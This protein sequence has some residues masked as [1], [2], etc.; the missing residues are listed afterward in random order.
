MVK[1]ILRRVEALDKIYPKPSVGEMA[2]KIVADR[3]RSLGLGHLVMDLPPAE[4]DNEQI[5]AFMLSHVNEF[6]GIGVLPKG[7]LTE[8]EM[9]S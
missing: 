2:N 6:L 8:E 3:L 9:R 5:A 1:R 4:M 7:F